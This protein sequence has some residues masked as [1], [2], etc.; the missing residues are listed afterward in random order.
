MNLYTDELEFFDKELLI[1]HFTKKKTNPLSKQ[2]AIK[3]L[4]NLEASYRQRLNKIKECDFSNKELILKQLLEQLSQFERDYEVYGENIYKEYET[5]K[6]E[7]IWFYSKILEEL[8]ELNENINT[9]DLFNK[10]NNKFFDLFVNFYFYTKENKI[11]ADSILGTSSINI[12]DTTWKKE[13]GVEIKEYELKENDD[14]YIEISKS[15]AEV[16]EDFFMKDINLIY[17]QNIKKALDY[18]IFYFTGKKRKILDKP[19]LSHALETMLIASSLTSDENVLISALLHGV[20]KNSDSNI[21]E[22]KKYFG[23]NIA[24]KILF[25]TNMEENFNNEKDWSEGK[26]NIL[27]KL[28]SANIEI[29]ILVLSNELSK[30]R[31]IDKDFETYKDKVW[32]YFNEPD[33]NK[34]KWYHEEVL[35][36]L[37]PLR[38]SGAYDEYKELIY[39]NLTNIY[40]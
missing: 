19:Y 4:N 12:H 22:I 30:L 1:E 18:A 36:R 13:I 26:K 32:S 15:E 2:Q 10:C 39:K 3:Y 40:N 23:M 14:Y 7:Q 8:K 37:Y 35:E 5:E 38:L 6:F 21:I 31:E 17:S 33:K 27:Y 24:E 9:K 20:V 29:K 11:Y 16:L 28:D 34:H 25:M